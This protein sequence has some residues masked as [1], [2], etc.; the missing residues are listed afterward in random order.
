MHKSSTALSRG[1]SVR[2]TVVG[3]GIL[4][5]TRQQR[6]HNTNKWHVNTSVA[7]NVLKLMKILIDIDAIF[8]DNWVTVEYENWGDI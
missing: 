2:W 3:S 6:L 5:Y 4:K 1:F 8:T 7:A